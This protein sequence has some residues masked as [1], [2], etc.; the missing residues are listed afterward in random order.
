MIPDIC[1]M[2][3]L[4]VS[5]TT[6]E[7]QPTIDAMVASGGVFGSHR[8]RL[9]TLITGVGG[10]A[11][12]WSLMRQ[13]GSGR[14]DLVVQAGIAGTL[15]DRKLGEV[16]M[17]EADELADIGVWEE[18]RFKTVFD[19]GFV[20]FDGG[21][22]AHGRLVNPYRQLMALTGLEAVAGLTVNEITT[23]VERISWYQQNTFAVVESMEGAPLHYVCLQEQ[24][25][26]LQLRSVSNLVGVR[27][28]S[29]W[30][31]RGAIAALN[32]EL[33]ALLENPGLVNDI[34]V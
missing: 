20:D 21:P 13:I 29:Q 34:L 11:T 10:I 28:K 7:I 31:I 8:H 17:I 15:R 22:F 30:D 14:P 23:N 6:F 2:H 26:F 25:P 24:I 9:E 4:L 19:M 18:G 3:I 12:T 33:L 16:F 27:N 1:S 32:R 5:A